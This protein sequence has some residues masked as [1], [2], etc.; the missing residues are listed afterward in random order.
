MFHCLR[1]QFC[2]KV[3]LSLFLFLFSL[4]CTRLPFLS[5]LSLSGRSLDHNFKQGTAD[6]LYRRD[7][8]IKRVLIPSAQPIDEETSKNPDSTDRK[9]RHS[10]YPD[11]YEKKDSKL[12]AVPLSA[13]LKIRT[14][15]SKGQ[16]GIVSFAKENIHIDP[17]ISFINE[18]EILDYEIVR[19]KTKWQNM[20]AKLLGRV[21]KF[22]GFPETEYYILPKE[23]GNYLILYKVAKQE[24]IPYDELPLARALG[25]LLAVPLV[26]YSVEH[27]VPE[28]IP[29]K[30]YR[31][32]GQYRP[33]CEGIRRGKYIRLKETAK[34][35]FQYEEKW[36]F[37]PRD[38]FSGQ[39][40]YHR[41]VVRSPET[42]EVGHT[43][44]DSAHLV[45]FHPT[46]G[47]LDVLDAS[48]DKIKKE[49]RIP[50][51]FIPVEW[52][53]YRIKRDSENLDPSFSEEIIAKV[54]DSSLRYLKIKFKELV[55]NQIPNYSGEKTLKAVFITD[56]YFS[57][58][59]EIAA[60]GT[61]AYV[62]K[63][64]FKK[65]MIDSKADSY[66]EKQWFES[67]STLFFPSFTEERRYY[68]STL[69]HT[70]ADK[71]KFLR[72]TRFDPQREKITWYFS[73]QT[74]HP[75]DRPELGWIRE[76][77]RKAVFLLNQA[78]KEANKCPSPEDRNKK[79]SKNNIT[80]V[81]D[82]SEDRSKDRE[83]GDIRYNILNLMF[84]EGKQNS[85]LLGLGP[86][87][88]DPITGE[89][90][91]AT[92]N[93]WV[94]HALSIYIRILR[95]YIRFQVYPPTWKLNPHLEGTTMFL[96]EKIQKVCPEVSSFIEK[97]QNRRFD[98][99]NPN[100]YDNER[101][102]TCASK[103]SRPFVL[104]VILHEMLH[105]FANRHIFSASVDSE[106]FYK[107]YDEIKSLFG[108]EIFVDATESH[109]HP[110]Q[111]SS[112]MDYMSWDYPILSVPGKLD[113]AV[114][115]FIYFD[116]VELVNG[117]FLKVPSG[118]N[119]KE[120][121]NSQKSILQTVKNTGLESKEIKP[122]KML[123]GGKKET[124]PNEPLCAKFDY[125]TNPLEIVQ[126]SIVLTD[127]YLMAGR[128]LYD[129][130][131]IASPTIAFI[132]WVA[133]L[134][135]KWKQLRDNLL[136]KKGKHIFDYSFLDS[137]HRG[138][139]E[140]IIEEEA[141]G[142]EY[143]RIVKKEAIGNS[144]FQSYA[145]IRQPIFDYIIKLAFM[146]VKHCIYKD[147]NDFYSAVALENIKAELSVDFVAYPDD[148]AEFMD[149]KSPVVRQWQ[150]DKLVAEVGF[151]GSN[152]VYSLRPKSNESFDEL[153]AFETFKSL[154]LE[155]EASN[156]FFDM[157]Q[158]P[159]FTDQYYQKMR[160]YVFSGIDFNPY[161]DRTKNP[162]IP[163]DDQN[164]PA[165]PPFLSYNI[166]AQMSIDG[167]LTLHEWRQWPLRLA[168]HSFQRESRNLS[169]KQN[170]W[171]HF[172]AKRID[173]MEMM[174]I[175]ESTENSIGTYDESNYPFFS[176]AWEEYV[177]LRPG[178][179]FAE[180]I[181]EHSA[182][183]DVE[184][185]GFFIPYTGEGFAAR[186]FQRYDN[187]SKCLE[188]DRTGLQVC[189][190]KEDKQT[191][192]RAVFRDY[193]QGHVEVKTR[194]EK[195]PFMAC[196]PSSQ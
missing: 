87:V 63:Y 90:I 187:F 46:V 96:H 104:G 140:R 106:N 85:G 68:D 164:Y 7:D 118:V 59:I 169:A 113:I 196:K 173:L 8:L 138:E 42:S 128:N 17:Q 174:Q 66:I 20:I 51:L 2:R 137:G 86:N 37:F 29:D 49:D 161:I 55:E 36:D 100:L 115:R 158:D 186:L 147:A 176:E 120:P 150:K 166:D 69:D 41:T 97:N 133:P 141:I 157:T 162:D 52:A 50:A 73:K 182:T 27:C 171:F 40:F 39:W 114:L 75:K 21:E 67:D 172:G 119:E 94:N 72:T 170:I 10:K 78:F 91:S 177:K 116:H 160:D 83:V 25:D 77:G 143:E 12:E 184:E 146:P 15:P 124:D 11:L 9:N 142:K 126:N 38:F 1:F 64:A 57:F 108:S 165:L 191:F 22:K 14:G 23:E 13:L 188:D 144:H 61:G 65:K 31:E 35:L 167:L 34:Q 103:L 194:I 163:H 89:V 80:I 148:S 112:V 58:N 183:L 121:Q 105:G 153:S 179:T 47:K 159:L 3:I 98:R 48:S 193:H 181:K 123:C 125:G 5:N 136:E 132:N 99:N 26:G 44:F 107:S 130:E 122:Y 145:A 156:D 88:A 30:N 101:I 62:L 131:G 189:F 6:D 92:A 151:F 190:D 18:Y 155:C 152:Q 185:K 117:N 4:S 180:F 93:V 110:P 135:K 56:N 154:L 149:C 195:D 19:P 84:T 82:E 74:P 178:N 76:L 70:K 33:L 102:K 139:Y 79:C 192:L 16:K 53:D 109:P 43:L 54:Y 95:R 127:N 111:Y 129:S 175:S 60:T 24:H 71:E 168:V 134:Y 81:L 45:E 28:V 32:T